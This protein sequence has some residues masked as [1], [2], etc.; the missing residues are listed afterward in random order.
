MKEI[1]MNSVGQ[2]NLVIDIADQ[3]N[4]KIRPELPAN[5]FIWFTNCSKSN[6]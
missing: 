4:V 1:V 3:E 2:R 6:K 5:Y